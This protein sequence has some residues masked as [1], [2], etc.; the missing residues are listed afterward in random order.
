M[1]KRVLLTQLGETP[2]P[3]ELHVKATFEAAGWE[4]EVEKGDFNGVKFLNLTQDSLFLTP[5]DVKA[6]T[7]YLDKR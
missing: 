5:E 3:A 4:V 1:T 6:A 7:D 2:T